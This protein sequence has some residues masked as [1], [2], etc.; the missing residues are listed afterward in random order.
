MIRL[1]I[2]PT[3]LD[4]GYKGKVRVQPTVLIRELYAIGRLN[5]DEVQTL[6]SARQQRTTIAH[7]LIS[8]PVDREVVL[9]IVRLADRLLNSLAAPPAR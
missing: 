6:E 4:A 8:E 9:Q 2:R 5:R 1:L 3:A 7:G